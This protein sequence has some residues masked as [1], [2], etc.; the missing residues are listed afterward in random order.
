[1]LFA[2]TLFQHGALCLYSLNHYDCQKH[3][4]C[5]LSITGSENV[6]NR[7]VPNEVPYEVP[8]QILYEVPNE[9]PYEL[10][11]SNCPIF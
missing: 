3:L 5:R 8:Y 11:T 4:I 7:K 6:F 2:V 9:V 1:M 10:H